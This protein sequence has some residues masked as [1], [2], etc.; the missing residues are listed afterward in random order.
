[1]THSALLLAFCNKEHSRSQQA[2]L[3]AN[4]FKEKEKA[5]CFKQPHLYHLEIVKKIDEI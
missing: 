5:V 4:G 3:L 2:G 1:M